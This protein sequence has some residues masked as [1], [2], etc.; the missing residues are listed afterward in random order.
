[1]SRATHLKTG[2]IAS[3]IGTIATC[4]TS[5]AI[6]ANSVPEGSVVITGGKVVQPPVLT[7]DE[8]KRPYAKYFYMPMAKPDTRLVAEVENG[9]IDPDKAL[10]I[11][12]LNDLLKPGYLASEVGYTIL[13]DGTGY[14]SSIVKMP[15]V[16]P[17]MLNWWFA[18]HPVEA[19]RYKIW[20][21]YVHYN[22]RVSAADKQQLLDEN[23][24]W[25]E[26]LWHT[27]HHVTEDIGV[28][29]SEISINFVSPAEFG[30]D[31]QKYNASGVG[32]AICAVG[33]AKMLHIARTTQDGGVELRTRFWFPA[34]AK[35]PMEMLKGLNLH[36]LEEYSNL[37][38]FLP[39]IYREF[40]PK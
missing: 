29:P 3:I 11:Q 16:T 25:N 15:G 1:M 4:C 26:R 32:T 34:E 18:W 6:A 17:E 38:S 28:G 13:P 20:D 12:D 30:F 31:M 37:A 8:Q 10:K 36:A 40:G 14:V 35:V 39:E 7:A 23:K 19:L 27:T 33:A 5:L 21:H 9:P 22:I 24:P 2:I